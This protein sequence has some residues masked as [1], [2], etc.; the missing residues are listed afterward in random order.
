[1]SII[2]VDSLCK[3]F[4]ETTVLR[5]VSLTVEPGERLAIIG[6]SGSG[7]SVFLRLLARLETPEAGTIHIGDDEITAKGADLDRIRKRMG[8]VPQGFHLF[9]HLN[10]IDNITLA[11]RWLKNTPRREAEA[12]ALDLLHMVGLDAKGHAMPHE[13]SGGQK[14]RVAIVRSLAMQPQVLLLDEPTSAL[15]PAMVGEV[16]ATLRLLAKRDLTMLIVTHELHVARD[17]A[18]RVLFFDEQTLYEE[19][20]PEALLDAPRKA[21]TRAFMQQLRHVGMSITSRSFDLMHLHGQLM[22]F[23]EKY[24]IDNRTAYHVELCAEELISEMLSGCYNATEPVELTLCIEHSDAQ[25]R[26]LLTC[27]A[28]GKCHDPFAACPTDEEALGML[29]VKKLVSAY[30]Y[31]HVDGSN[32][33]TVTL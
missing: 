24:G 33:V 8:M 14:Q 18:S 3:R 6:P 12:E 28:G 31:E 13:L 1:M 7:K 30:H 22:I 9:E 2:R 29:L 32:V 25:K 5:N 16:L 17:I 19:G 21:R 4:G 15:D 27:R 20:T 10:V 23:S 26:T 11:P